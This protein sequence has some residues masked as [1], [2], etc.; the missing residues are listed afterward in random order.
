MI[1]YVTG[2]PGSGKSYYG[3]FQ[4]S[5]HFNNNLATNK[6]FANLNKKDRASKK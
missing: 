5:I 4:I 1:Q 6:K 3:L 2:I